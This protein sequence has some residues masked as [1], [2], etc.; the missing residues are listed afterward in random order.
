MSKLLRAE[1]LQTQNISI[2]NA[3]SDR[4]EIPSLYIKEY[5]EEINVTWK[6]TQASVPGKIRSR[7]GER[8]GTKIS[9]NTMLE[10]RKAKSV[11]R[12]N[13]QQELQ[14]KV[15]NVEHDEGTT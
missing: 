11:G 9:I 5:S 10:N 2:P 14:E 1:Q 7:Q 3:D 8:D 4:Q 15:M 12:T 13:K 6:R